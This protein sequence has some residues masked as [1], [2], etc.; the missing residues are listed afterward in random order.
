MKTTTSTLKTYTSTLF[1]L[2]C[3]LTFLTGCSQSGQRDAY[4]T[5]RG[6]VWHTLYNITYAGPES[7]G[8]SLKVVMDSV[9]HTLSV[10]DETSLVSKVNTSRRTIVDHAFR[11][12]YAMSVRVNKQS[13]GMFD[14]TLSPL[15]TA[16]GFGKNHHATA[17]TLRIDSL[18]S[19]TGIAR[20]HL[21]G[22]TLVKDDE[23]IEFN[24]SAIAKGYGCDRVAA[25]LRR[26]GVSDYMIEIGGEIVASGK[27][28]RGHDWR[29]AIERPQEEHQGDVQ[30]VVEFTDMAMA[31][32]GDYRNYHRSGSGQYGHTISPLTGRPAGTDLVSVT[33]MAPTCMEADALAT[34]SMALG[35]GLGAKMLDDLGL[36]YLMICNSGEVIDHLDRH[37]FN[38]SVSEPDS[39][40]RN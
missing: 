40:G 1:F 33:V 10:F 22:D 21:E 16:W 23:R 17:D 19:I 24:F 4:V 28:S 15:I 35:S 32:S 20:T 8:D 26:N 14:P 13:H 34:A 25:M 18:L 29:V 31:T 5:Q 37:N 7:L 27:S 30:T 9:E 12:V 11:D 39:R 36:P 3:I 2:A 6:E 38:V